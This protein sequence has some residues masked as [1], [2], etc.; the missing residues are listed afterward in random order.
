MLINISPVIKSINT[1]CLIPK[2][3]YIITIDIINIGILNLYDI[4]FD[5]KEDN[6]NSVAIAQCILGKQ[7]IGGVSKKNITCARQ[8]IA[9]SH[10]TSGL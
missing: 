2:V 6:I 7:L 4:F 9:S 3:A 8:D 1:C 10:T 5:E